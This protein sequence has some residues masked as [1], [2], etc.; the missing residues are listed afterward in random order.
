MAK[1][2][3]RCVYIFIFCN[4]AKPS[5]FTNNAGEKTKVLSEIEG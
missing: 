5:W 1:T 2:G 4:M 3:T